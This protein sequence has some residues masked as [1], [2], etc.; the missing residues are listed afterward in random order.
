MHRAF[1]RSRL[2]LKLRRL[3]S[4]F[5]I[6]AP[7]LAVHTHVPW[8]WRALAAVVVLG[9]GL[10]LAGWVY[11]AGRRYAG[12]ERAETDSEISILRDKVVHQDAEV[13]RLR[14]LANAGESQ[15]QIDHAT[16]QRLT[17][18]VRLLE[19]ENSQLK[20]NLAVFEN[21]AA[22]GGKT[23]G[24]SLGRLRVEPDATPGKYRY[25]VLASQR[26]AEAKQEFRGVLQ[27]QVTVVAAT[28]HSAIIVLPHP[29]DSDA[30]KFAVSFRAFR[31]LEGSFHVPVDATVKR[32][33]VRLMQDGAVMASQSVSL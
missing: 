24:V 1:A 21:L 31:S 9:L 11:D 16:V 13:A 30:G 26:G 6:A 29:D 27:F 23:S 28:G 18:Q 14:G 22:G 4:R 10:A 15:Q 12:F 8:Y 7:R 17:A 32:V 19:D 25:R 20:E 5:G 33:E 2:A 3:R